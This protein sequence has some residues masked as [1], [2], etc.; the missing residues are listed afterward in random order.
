MLP[1]GASAAAAYQRVRLEEI[2]DLYGEL[3]LDLN[4]YLDIELDVSERLDSAEEEAS[5]IGTMF[6][7]LGIDLR[8]IEPDEGLDDNSF[9]QIP[10]SK[11]YRKIELGNADDFESLVGEARLIWRSLAWI[12][13]KTPCFR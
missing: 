12:W 11:E 3:D 4:Q 2:R 5:E 1:E 9:T 13:R 10:S 7:S 6:S 8:A